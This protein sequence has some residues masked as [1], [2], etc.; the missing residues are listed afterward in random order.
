MGIKTRLNLM[1]FLE[2]AAKGLWFP[3]ASVFLTAST[4]EGGLGFTQQQ[5]GWIIGI[6]LAV[7]SCCAPFIGRLCDKRFATEKCLALLL[8]W[9][10]CLHAPASMTVNSITKHWIDLL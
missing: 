9:K 1:M 6:P 2:Y 8:A 7:G 10:V 4:V 3:L 5:K